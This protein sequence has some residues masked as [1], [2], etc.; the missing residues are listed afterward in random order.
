MTPVSWCESALAVSCFVKAFG[1]EFLHNDAGLWEAV[2]SMSIF[3]KNIAIRIHF[4][5]ECI[6]IDDVLWEEFKFHPEVLE[7][8]HGRHEVE[9][10]DVDS[11]ELCIGHGDDAVE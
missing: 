5:T 7:V 11:H 4:V 10:L 1:E 2:H 8:I 3:T 6:F 9:V